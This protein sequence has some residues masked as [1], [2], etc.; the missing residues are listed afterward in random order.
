MFVS[1]CYGFIRD[2][3]LIV[4][5]QILTARP[6]FFQTLNRRLHGCASILI[7][8]A[9]LITR[10]VINEQ[11]AHISGFTQITFG[12]VLIRTR[13]SIRHTTV[14]DLLF[15]RCQMRAQIHFRWQRLSGI[16]N[17]MAF[18]IR[19]N[20]THTTTT[21]FLLTRFHTLYPLEVL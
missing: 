14:T 10:V 16:T 8:I 19:R 2:R 17:P 12:K 13:T 1:L 6:V 18:R 4:R 11:T 9:F 21:D 7:R 5:P 15:H 20:F 3:V